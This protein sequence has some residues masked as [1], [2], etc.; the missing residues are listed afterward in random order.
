[1][2]TAHLDGQLGNLGTCRVT[3]K[4]EIVRDEVARYCSRTVGP[5]LR[6]DGSFEEEKISIWL[7]HSL[8]KTLKRSKY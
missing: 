8:G 5:Q 4:K 7:S 2:K 1:M 3:G 6:S